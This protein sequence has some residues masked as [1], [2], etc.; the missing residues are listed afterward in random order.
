MYDNLCNIGKGR[1]DYNISNNPK[2]WSRGSKHSEKTKKLISER[3]KG[4]PKP[5]SKDHKKKLSEAA[6]RRWNK[7]Q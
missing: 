4:I 5:F 7:N 6:K 1:G 2:A 3:C